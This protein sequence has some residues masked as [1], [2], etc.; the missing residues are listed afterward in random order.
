MK[1]LCLLVILSYLLTGCYN[2]ELKDEKKLYNEYVKELKNASEDNFDNKF[3][4][5]LNIYLE[6]IIDEEVVCRVI[7]D[8]PTST[9]NNIKAIVI[10]DYETNNI[11]P[12][13]GIFDEPLH[14]KPNFVNKEEGYVK[15]IVLVSYIPFEDN[16]EDF[17]ALIKILVSYEQEGKSKK[18]LYKYKN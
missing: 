7:I 16:I 9:I 5:D 12:T 4:F 10:H 13:I 17:N 3:P 15:G 14:L 18:V 1:K 11:Y 8:N 6:K 2:N